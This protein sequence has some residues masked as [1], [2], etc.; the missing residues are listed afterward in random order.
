[1]GDVEATENTGLLGTKFAAEVDLAAASSKTFGMVVLGVEVVVVL[2][3]LFMF[4]YGNVD[5]FTTQKYIIVRDIMVMLLLGFGYLMTFLK[6]YGLGAVGFTL[7][8][9]AIN[10]QCNLI[11]ESVLNGDLTISLDSIM[12]AEFS[13][14]TLLISFGPLIGR[15]TPLQMCTVAVAESLFYALN[16]VIVVFGFLNAEDVGGSLTIHMF[17][18]YFGLALAKTLGPQDKP[19]AETNNAPSRTSDVFAFIGTLLLWVYWPSFVGAT[20]TGT[21]LYE[22]RCLINTIMALLG[23]TGAAFL[24]SQY[25][26]HGKFDAVHM[27]N[28]TLAGGVAIGATAR[29]GM[30]PGVALL[31][32]IAAGLV[33][34]AGYVYS[35]P[36]LE[37]KFGVYDT[38]GVGNLHGYPSIVGG[39]ASII[40]VYFHS[41]EPFLVYTAGTQSVRQLAAIVATIAS[42]SIAGY[43]TGLVLLKT[44]ASFETVPDYEDTVWWHGVGE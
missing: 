18:A 17:G 24:L 40:I 23:S 35:S 26:N 43:V 1:M 21:D 27:Q 30:G 34:V 42:S 3:L 9:T 37:T 41:E 4:D 39:L 19:S 2:A 25:L 38:C 8:I 31:I 20:E 7:L 16:K 13:A 12:N 5:D 11:I 29:I 15:A 44:P 14:A 33:S 22:M 28:S 6:H 36:Y 10:M 32:G